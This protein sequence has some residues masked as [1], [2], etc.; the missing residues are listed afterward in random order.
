LS[1]WRR[2]LGFDS[3]MGV[4]RYLLTT[5]IRASAEKVRLDSRARFTGEIY[6]DTLVVTEGA[7]FHGS[8]MAFDDNDSGDEDND[9]REGPVSDYSSESEAQLAN[10]YVPSLS[11]EVTEADLQVAFGKYGRIDP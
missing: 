10:I 9:G 7:V 5:D 4:T 6:A 2:F 3:G 8:S 11:P 1:W